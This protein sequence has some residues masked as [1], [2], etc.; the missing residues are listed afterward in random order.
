MHW[1]HCRLQPPDPDDAK[2]WLRANHWSQD[3][4]ASADA[5]FR[6]GVPM[7]CGLS[8]WSSSGRP[9]VG[10]TIR[11]LAAGHPLAF[12]VEMMIEREAGKFGGPLDSV[13][14]VEQRRHFVRGLLREIARHMA[15]DQTEAIDEVTICMARRD[16]RAGRPGSGIPRA[17]EE[18]GRCRRLSRE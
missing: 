16:R 13:L 5:L 4:I 8:F 3:D 7:R 17:A 15:D 11:E 1:K 9:G 6:P 12:L 10:S 14:S 18:P 2:A